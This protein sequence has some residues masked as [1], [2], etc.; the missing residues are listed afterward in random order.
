MILEKKYLSG[1]HTLNYY[2][3]NEKSILHGLISLS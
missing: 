3:F 1:T 2:S